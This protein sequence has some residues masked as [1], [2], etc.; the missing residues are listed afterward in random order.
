M[1]MVQNY[2]QSVLNY[3]NIKIR[4]DSVPESTKI[5]MGKIVQLFWTLHTD[6]PDA[7]VVLGV[8]AQKG[9]GAE[10]SMWATVK[11]S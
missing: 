1:I 3:S 5:F 11:N 7:S 2:F 10:Y 8:G 4:D 6:I 9:R